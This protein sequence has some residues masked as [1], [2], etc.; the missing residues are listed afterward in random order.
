MSPPNKHAVGLT[1]SV[2]KP[3]YKDALKQLVP[4][5]NFAAH[6]SPF[7]KKAALAAIGGARIESSGAWL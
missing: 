3:I 4:L 6:E 1:L 7:S 5:R 2:K